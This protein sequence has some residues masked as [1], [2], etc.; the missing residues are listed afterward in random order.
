MTK[1]VSSVGLLGKYTLVS[2]LATVVDFSTFAFGQAFWS[3]T[4]F[5]ATVL[6]QCLGSL[7]AFWYHRTWVFYNGKGHF[8]TLLVIK[9]VTGVLVTTGLNVLGVWFFHDFLNV[10]A[11][12][13]R[14]SV[15]LC[16]WCLGFI[17]NKTVVFK[18]N[19]E[20]KEDFDPNVVNDQ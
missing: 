8:S 11:W 14:V 2:L 5:Q 7:V 16:V 12:F 20:L 10:D 3:A 15:A 19:R 18:E 1:L 13:S 17:F 9:Y 6:G 4:V